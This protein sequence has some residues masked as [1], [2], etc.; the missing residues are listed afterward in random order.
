MS[1]AGQQESYLYVRGEDAVLEAV[2]RCWASL[3]TA[4]AIAYRTK[5]GIDHASVSMAVV[6]Q[7]MVP[8]EVSGVL[9]TANPTTGERTE[10]VVNA[11]FGLGEAVVSGQRHARLLPAG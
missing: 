9:L 8:S 11:S 10:M 3:W 2:R 6:I 1:F 5:M 7:E 4:R